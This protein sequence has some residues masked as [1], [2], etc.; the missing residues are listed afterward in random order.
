M[1]II[2]RN[3][4]ILFIISNFTLSSQNNKEDIYN[5]D[6]SVVNFIYDLVENPYKIQN[7]E[8]FFPNF[9][10]STIISIDYKDSAVINKWEKLLFIVPI[11]SLTDSLFYKESYPMDEYLRF[12][13]MRM[14]KQDI[15]ANDIYSIT[16]YVDK[17]WRIYFDFIKFKNKFYFHEL[18]KNG[19]YNCDERD[20]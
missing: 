15:R 10:D 2:L 1:K 20:D 4:I 6:S 18:Y 9:Y 5:V 12:Y 8:K 13:K 7:L 11:K 19:L 17:C 14:L 16:V 3:I